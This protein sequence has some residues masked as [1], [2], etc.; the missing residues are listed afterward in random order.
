MKKKTPPVPN[1]YTSPLQTQAQQVADTSRS[2][3]TQTL[4]AAKGAYGNFIPGSEGSSAH[5]RNLFAGLSGTVARGNEN[6]M[7]RMR[8]RAQAAG[9]AGQPITMAAEN[10]VANEGAGRIAQ[11]PLQVEEAAM[12]YEMQGIQGLTGIGQGEVADARSMFGQ[13]TGMEDA[14]LAAY[15]KQQEE[16]RKRKAGIWGTLARLGLNVGGS[17]A[18]MPGLG[19]MTLGSPR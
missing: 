4:E 12:P 3:G 5:R 8:E 7:A 18:G 1:T 10:E 6:Q 14:R 2:A 17:F 15:Y 16:A 11:I 9:F 19:N 13:A